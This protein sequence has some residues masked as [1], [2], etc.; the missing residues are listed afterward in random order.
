MGTSETLRFLTAVRSAVRFPCARTRF[1]VQNLLPSITPGRFVQA[2][3]VCEVPSGTLPFPA[4]CFFPKIELLDLPFLTFYTIPIRFYLQKL[5]QF[6][7]VD[8]SAKSMKSDNQFSGE[9]SIS[10]VDS[11]VIIIINY[12]KYKKILLAKRNYNVCAEF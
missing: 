3:S 2:C 7:N 4:S 11:V 8:V 1:P 12:K 10:L 5:F 9:S 6:G